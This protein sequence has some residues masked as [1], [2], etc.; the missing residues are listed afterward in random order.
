MLLGPSLAVI[1]VGINVHLSPGARRAIEQPVTD[2]ASVSGARS[3]DRNLLLARILEELAAMLETYETAGFAPFRAAWCSGG[4]RCRASRCRSCCPMAVWRAAGSLASTP[5]AR[6]T[7]SA[8]RPAVR[9][10]RGIAR[11]N[12][13]MILVLDCG[14]SRFKWGLA[15]P[16]GWVSQGNVP[17]QE[18]GT[19]ALR[20]WQNL[21]RPERV[22]GVNVAGEALRVRVE[23][24]LVR[25]RLVREWLIAHEEA[26]GVY[27]RYARPSQLGADLWAALVA[28]RQR[29]AEELFPPACVVVNAGTALTVDALDASGVFRGSIICRAST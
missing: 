4:T 20:D 10:R 3:L 22:V 8:V 28:V 9:E 15:G 16:H 25:W 5:M 23:A 2:L 29:V 27:N 11:P 26:A 21:Q 24:Q 17:N 14:N 6:C 18:I 19:L 7:D 1:G 12:A 13:P